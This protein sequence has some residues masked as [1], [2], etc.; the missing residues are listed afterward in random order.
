MNF[1][2]CIYIYPTYFPLFFPSVLD[3]LKLHQFK[4]KEESELL[5]FFLYLKM[6]VFTLKEKEKY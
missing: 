6:S 2:C 4:K 5:A 1:C 3:Q